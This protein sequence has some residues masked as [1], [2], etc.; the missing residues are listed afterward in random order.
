M[1]QMTVLVATDGSA[2]AQVALDLAARIPWPE[3][4]AIHLVTVVER[5]S[6]AYVPSAPGAIAD[7]VEREVPMIGG[8]ATELEHMAAP[9]RETG[10]QVETH[11]LIGRPAT[12]IVD[13]AELL[14]A[15]VI[16]VGSRGH[17]TIG[18]MLLGS[19]SAEVADHAHCPV[20]VARKSTWSRAILGVDGSSFGEAAER[21]VGTW[22]IF[23]ATPVEVLSVTDMNLSWPSSLAL[24]A[25]AGSID[26]PQT[27]RAIAAQHQLWADEATHRLRKQGR[28]AVTRPIQGDPAEEIVRCARDD[29]ADVIVVGTHGRTGLRRALAG[30]VAR[31]VM[32]HAPCSVLVVRETRPLT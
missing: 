28:V 12:A 25:Y 26:Y 3:S 19:V 1:N 5:A 30:S 22:P 9:L 18:S 4:C 29:E 20:I 27:E 31:N 11:M 17:G 10:A 15:D 6:V 8:L 7:P 14:K 21:V 16:V 24:S 32:L 13:E 23:A 2:C